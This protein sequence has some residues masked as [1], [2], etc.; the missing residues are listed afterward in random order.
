MLVSEKAVRRTTYGDTGTTVD[1]GQGGAGEGAARLGCMVDMDAGLADGWTTT[2]LQAQLEII[3]NLTK[4]YAS[5][6]VTF[7]LYRME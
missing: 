6:D 2:R 4:S 3:I 7:V 5:R 1:G